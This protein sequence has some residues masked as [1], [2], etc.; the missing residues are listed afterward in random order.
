MSSDLG[1]NKY[2]SKNNIYF[3]VISPIS[4][5]MLFYKLYQC[6]T[7]IIIHLIYVTDM[8]ISHSKVDC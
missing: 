1:N 6:S 5:T 8:N 3:T 4:R 2:I 7:G